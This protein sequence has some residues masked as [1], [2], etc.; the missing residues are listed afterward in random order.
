MFSGMHEKPL[1]EQLVE[2]RDKIEHQIHILGND[3]AGGDFYGWGE[4]QNKRENL[5]DTLRVAL[6]GIDK[7]LA[8]LGSDN[9]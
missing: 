3:P 4:N 8:D 6:R 5:R 7:A 2:L 9:A 1:R